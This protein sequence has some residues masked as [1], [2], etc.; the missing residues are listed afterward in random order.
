MSMHELKPEA[1]KNRVFCQVHTRKIDRGVAH[2]NME[3]AGLKRVNKHD[4][5]KYQTM[6]GMIM[7]EYLPSYFAKHWRD[8]VNVSNID[9][10][11]AFK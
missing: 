1:P 3:I 4:Y 11:R 9:L 10:R 5:A 8:T 6:T 7:Q 2:H